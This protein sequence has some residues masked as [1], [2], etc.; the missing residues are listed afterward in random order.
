MPNENK[1]T[2]ALDRQY[3]ATKKEKPSVSDYHD[4]VLMSHKP[5]TAVTL[6]RFSSLHIPASMAQVR[7]SYY[8]H[9]C[10]S[11]NTRRLQ[12]TQTRRPRSAICEV[13]SAFEA[14]RS[15]RLTRAGSLSPF[16]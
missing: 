6:R 12:A 1:S 11:L 15:L 3:E 5:Q 13:P 16:T 7:A 4:R 14:Q 2:G 8:S 9:A 10:T